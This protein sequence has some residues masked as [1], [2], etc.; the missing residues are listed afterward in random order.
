MIEDDV[1]WMNIREKE[2]KIEWC[3]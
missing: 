1:E 3:F 2:M